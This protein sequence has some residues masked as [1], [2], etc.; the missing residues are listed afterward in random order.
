MK[1][2]VIIGADFVPS[3]LPPAT[4]IRFFATHLPEFG[5]EPIVL[6][7]KPSF[8]DWPVDAENEQ[9]IAESLAIVRTDALRSSWT[10]KLG[11]GD[12]GIRSLKEAW[13]ALKQLC[14]EQHIDLIF[15][16]VPPYVSMALGRLA[17]RKFGIPYVID[18]IDPWVT[19]YYWKLPKQQRPPKWALA[20]ALSRMVEPFTLRRVA[21]ITGVS[22]GTT[23]SVVERYGSLSVADATEI[24]YGAEPADFE[25]LRQHPRRNG[26]FDKNDGLFHL[27][28][29]GAC[30]PGMHA[31]VRA[32]FAAVRIGFESEP[33]LFQSLR[34]HFV[35]TSYA[36]NGSAPKLL[37]A[38]AQ[39]FGIEDYVDER[40]ARV[41]YLES[42]QIMLDSD[43]LFLVGSDEPH[44]TASKVFP[45]L[46]AARPL[47]AIFHEASSVTSILRQGAGTVV[48]FDSEQP[49]AAKSHE[50]FERLREM[51]AMKSGSSS[52]SSSGASLSMSEAAANAIEQYT[53]RAMTGRL[54]A[55]FD[56]ALETESQR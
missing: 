12:I 35:G 38:I 10:R 22:K 4:R 6:T 5:W 14:R 55:A 29:V 20:Y 31:S 49:P 40:P 41:V 46:L 34:L 47:L 43:G 8:Y 21:H 3:S 23:D 16:P 25:Y 52:D 26:V 27:S 30:I 9:L 32:L 28:C 11:I 48:S 24:P 39:E 44:Y 1:K 54:A 18:Y 7:T 37:P 17:H 15:I 42:L 51:L 13:R 53:T 50:I 45:Y 36:S 33:E 56:R 19:E 2:V